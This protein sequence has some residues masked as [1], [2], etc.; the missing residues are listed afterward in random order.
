MLNGAFDVEKLPLLC[1]R[2]QEERNNLHQCAPKTI[3][4]VF[5]WTLFQVAFDIGANFIAVLTIQ[6]HLDVKFAYVHWL[7]SANILMVGAGASVLKVVI[8][9]FDSSDVSSCS[10]TRLLDCMDSNRAFCLDRYSKFS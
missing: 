10:V 5:L 9:T 3:L 4:A 7:V 6:T 2:W 8:N 1:M